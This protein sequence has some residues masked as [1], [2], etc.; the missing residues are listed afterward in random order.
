MTEALGNTLACSGAEI[1]LFSGSKTLNE[2]GK[3]PL[4][5]EWLGNPSVAPSGEE[6]AQYMWLIGFVQ[7]G[8][9]APRFA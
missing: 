7:A 2:A 8:V 3:N 6:S 5:G 9:I 4:N 1:I